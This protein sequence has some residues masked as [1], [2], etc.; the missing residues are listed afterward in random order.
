MTVLATNYLTLVDVMKQTVGDSVET[1]IAE[2]LSESNDLLADLHV[3]ECNDGTSHKAVIRHGLPKGTFRKL[4]G[5][6]PTEK[7]TTEQVVD[8]T[9]ELESYSTPDIDLI[10]HS[11]NPAQTRLNEARAFIEGMGQTA[12]E[13][14]IYGSRAENDAK[15]DGLAVRYSKIST[16][17][18]SIGYNVI[19]AGGTGTNN[20]SIWFITTGENDVALLYPKGSK[21]GLQHFDDG[22]QTETNEKGEKR[23]VYQDH[24]KHSLGLT[25]KD[26]RS[27]CRIANIDVGKLLK[28]EVDLL[29]LLRKGYFRIKKRIKK[30]KNADQQVS[31]RTF[32]YCNS[33]VAEMLDA[34]AADKANVNLNIKEY[35]GADVAHYKNI[36]IREIDQI[37]ETEERVP[38][39]E[40]A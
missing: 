25:V 14:I 34:A 2:I 27:T 24:F 31:K 1:D 15:F 29:A 32:I 37:L 5:Y 7:S 11:K 39:E 9:G 17:K 35:C 4:Y 36:P 3:M 20:T 28:G 19:D 13:T 26:Y 6:V 16:N 10:D 18:K 40:A 21:A 23:K 33:T 22:I 38:E 8:V 30:N 12:Q